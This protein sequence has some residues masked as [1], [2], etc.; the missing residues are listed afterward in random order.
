MHLRITDLSHL[1]CCRF[2]FYD[3]MRRSKNLQSYHLIS[4]NMYN[5]TKTNR[6]CIRIYSYKYW[7]ASTRI[8]ILDTRKA[9]SSRDIGSS[10]RGTHGAINLGWISRVLEDPMP[11]GQAAL[12]WRSLYSICIAL[13]YYNKWRSPAQTTVTP[14]PWPGWAR[15]VNLVALTH[16]ARGDNDFKSHFWLETSSQKKPTQHPWAKI[17]KL[18]K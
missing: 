18:C 9:W 5:Q 16:S 15:N 17:C 4:G 3:K 13:T 2:I 12:R 6:L 10:N 7:Q 11:Q 14:T 1:L 8:K